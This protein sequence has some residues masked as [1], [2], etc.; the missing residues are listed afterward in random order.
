MT[1]MQHVKLFVEEKRS[2]P[3]QKKGYKI[4]VRVI[5]RFEL[6]NLDEIVEIRQAVTPMMSGQATKERINLIN[7][8]IVA[9]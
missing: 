5:E 3:T 1:L 8:F 4:L 6:A 2:T 9:V 7:A